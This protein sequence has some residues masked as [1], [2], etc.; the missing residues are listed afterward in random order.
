MG[1]HRLANP[2]YVQG[3]MGHS[4]WEKRNFLWVSGFSEEVLLPFTS[5]RSSAHAHQGEASPLKA[6]EKVGGASDAGG[7]ESLTYIL[8]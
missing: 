8:D 5:R 6:T 1:I 2:G 7:G 3:T 4:I